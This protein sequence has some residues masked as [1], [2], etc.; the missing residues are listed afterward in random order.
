MPKQLLLF[1]DVNSWIELGDGVAIK[2]D[3]PN[4]EQ[5]AE[6][7][8]IYNTIVM[9]RKQYFVNKGIDFSTLTADDIMN[10]SSETEEDI[11]HATELESLGRAAEGLLVKYSLKDWT[12][13]NN[14]NGEP[15][16]LKLKQSKGVNGT[17]LSDLIFNSI[18]Y[19]Q[20]LFKDI[21]IA[22]AKKLSFT[23]IDKKKS[24]SE[25]S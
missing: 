24:Q 6:I 17:E 11:K 15:I 22:I 25:E 5:H 1:D 2:I 19:N 10:Y 21:Y 12:G 18:T 9:K 20:E 23:E 7:Q 13:F 3:Y 4:V 14:V 16:M 8:K